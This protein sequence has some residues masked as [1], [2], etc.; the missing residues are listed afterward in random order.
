MAIAFTLV[1][2]AI[3]QPTTHDPKQRPVPGAA[4][5]TPEQS[6]AGVSNEDT[7]RLPGGNQSAA[8]S[9]DARPVPSADPQELNV[10]GLTTPPTTST[11]AENPTET[12]AP[13]AAGSTVI[14]PKPPA[15]DAELER[16][17]QLADETLS[18]G[19]QDLA[20]GVGTLSPTSGNT[21]EQELLA[22]AA[23]GWAI[24][25]ELTRQG[26]HIKLRLTAV[27]PGERILRSMTGDVTEDTLEVTLLRMLR[28]VHAFCTAAAPGTAPEPEPPPAPRE[29]DG[30]AY[31]AVT[32]A[33][34][35][36]YV[37]FSLEHIAGSSDAKLIYP[38]MTLGAGVGVG[39]SLV[40][41]DEWQVT[42]GEAWYLSATTLWSTT[43]ALL[44]SDGL[45]ER[46]ASNRHAYGLLGTATGLSL[47]T[48][49]ISVSDVGPGGALLTHSGAVFGGVFGALTERLV[50]ADVD[51]RPTLGLGIGL[52]AGTLVAGVAA[53]Q[54]PDPSPTRLV[55][56]DLSAFL[57]GLTGAAGASPALVG[58][59]VTPT[60]TRLWVGSVLTGTILGGILG[61]ALTR[62][63][64]PR[65]TTLPFLKRLTPMITQLDFGQNIGPRPWAAGAA[66]EW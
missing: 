18:E 53:T 45:S 8:T 56:I 12:Q 51:Q 47:G 4:E 33:M 60:E 10:D 43:S 15:I 25:A 57:G 27:A 31:L 36:G 38:L 6:A 64:Q 58:D 21:D 5:P 19:F 52:A 59:T 34:I 2:S 49:A 11:N 1:T 54:V 37:G 63:E 3:A 14:D 62:D 35:G 16:M 61:Y 29:A 55:Y 17:R 40:A 41:A 22:Q 44:I 30:R 50:E 20:I 13:T 46:R 65:T 28:D 24:A 7:T 23:S 32:G 9:N 42:T 26:Q 66:G 48:L 39:A